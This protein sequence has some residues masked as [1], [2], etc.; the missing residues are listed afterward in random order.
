MSTGAGPRE[1]GEQ[2]RALRGELAGL[3]AEREALPLRFLCVRVS[4]YGARL[5]PTKERTKE[6]TKAERIQLEPPAVYAVIRA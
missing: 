2:I 4:A 5:N 1:A 3:R 6:A